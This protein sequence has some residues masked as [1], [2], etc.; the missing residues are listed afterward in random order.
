MVHQLYDS[1]MDNKRPVLV[2]REEKTKL[3]LL[4]VDKQGLI[5]NALAKLLREQFFVVVVTAGAVEKHNNVVHVSYRRKI[6]MI[7]D[8][9]Y[10]HIFLVYNGEK[11]LLDMLPAFEDKAESVKG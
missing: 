2:T 4:I 7:P 11:E 6:P 3:P 5:G 1:A 8:N 10:S 9:A